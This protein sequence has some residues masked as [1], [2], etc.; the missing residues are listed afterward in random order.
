MEN[1]STTET[2]NIY[3]LRYYYGTPQKVLNEAITH[4]VA[5]AQIGNSAKQGLPR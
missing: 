4:D 2:E 5:S 1:K 3:L